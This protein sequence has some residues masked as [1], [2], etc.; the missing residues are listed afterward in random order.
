MRLL[1][2]RRGQ[3]AVDRGGKEE[4]PPRRRDG[5]RGVGMTTL[6]PLRALAAAGM[7]VCLLLANAVAEEPVHRIGVLRAA[8]FA[9]E[10]K[11]RWVEDL[12]ERGYA[13]GRNLQIEYR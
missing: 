12:G 4:A 9:P 6:R 13:E 3:R 2:D 1:L 5:A 8:E 11:K 7:A 10:L